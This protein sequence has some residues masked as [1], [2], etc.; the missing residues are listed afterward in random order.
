MNM[1]IMSGAPRLEL[2]T[3]AQATAAM[4]RRMP[5]CPS[6]KRHFE[7]QRRQPPSRSR[8]GQNTDRA[9]AVSGRGAVGPRAG[10]AVGEQQPGASW[11]LDRVGHVA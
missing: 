9:A 3:S 2:R 6:H 4:R 11:H 5:V 1:V 7:P 8:L 10:L